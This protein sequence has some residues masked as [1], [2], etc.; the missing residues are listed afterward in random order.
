MDMKLWDKPVEIELGRIGHCRVVTSTREAA[1]CLMTR[2]P[3]AG[4]PAQAAA[5]RACLEV[6]EGNAPP[7][8]AR[9]AFIDAAEEA[10]IF[11]RS[12]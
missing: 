7:E 10:G 6:L 2:W 4:G 1:E 3:E 8:V 12:K 11:V 5:R 9:Q